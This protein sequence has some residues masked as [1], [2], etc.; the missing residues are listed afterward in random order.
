MMWIVDHGGDYLRKVLPDD[1]K[2]LYK[3]DLNP[4]SGQ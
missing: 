4:P 2:A 1:W 3:W